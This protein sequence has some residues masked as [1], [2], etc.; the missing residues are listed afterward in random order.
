[1]CEFHWFT[2]ANVQPLQGRILK[3]YS[4]KGFISDAVDFSFHSVLI[5]VCCNGRDEK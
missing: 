2:T 5:K 4:L 3:D 1:M